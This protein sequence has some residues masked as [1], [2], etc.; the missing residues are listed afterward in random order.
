MILNI[1]PFFNQFNF[2]FLRK[3]GMGIN[4][5]TLRTEQYN[6]IYNIEYIHAQ[7]N[8]NILYYRFDNQKVRSSNKHLN[9]NFCA[10]R[11][12]TS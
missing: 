6:I 10:I 11:F 7:T 5:C 4:K 2:F 3:K 8:L 1:H 9:T 12:S